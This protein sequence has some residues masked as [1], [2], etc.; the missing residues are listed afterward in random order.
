MHPLRRSS[1]YYRRGVQGIAVA[2]PHDCKQGGQKGDQDVAEWLPE[3]NQGWLADQVV[4]VRQKFV[5]TIDPREAAA[6]DRVLA[7]CSTTAML[8]VPR[9]A[10]SPQRPTPP[11]SEALAR[12][13]D[14]GTGR[15]TCA[16]ARRHG[17]APV[18]RDHPADP[19]M[20]DADNDGIVCE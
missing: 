4:T 19:H 16:D 2:S 18:R 14:H 12:W 17:T 3:L 9:S 15:M 13:A 6:R 8:M 20:R 7:G 11:A 1:P 10:T 5:L